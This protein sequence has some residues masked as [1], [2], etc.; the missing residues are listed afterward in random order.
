MDEI[1]PIII[2]S[3]FFNFCILISAISQRHNPINRNKKVEIFECLQHWN[4][5]I[6]QARFL[7]NSLCLWRAPTNQV[8]MND[9]RPIIESPDFGDDFIGI[10]GGFLEDENE[11]FLISI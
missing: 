6:R 9:F 1:A 10:S 4:I 5:L 7:F 8:L 2:N 11:G 3:N